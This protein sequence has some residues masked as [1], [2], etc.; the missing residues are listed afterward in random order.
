MFEHKFLLA[1]DPYTFAEVRTYFDQVIVS[2]VNIGS[3]LCGKPGTHYGASLKRRISGA[4]VDSLDAFLRTPEGL[5]AEESTFQSVGV[6][7][8]QLLEQY[9]SGRGFLLFLQ[10]ELTVFH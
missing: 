5:T 8:P 2:D 7:N 6:E 10:S 1:C 3:G 4:I 9:N